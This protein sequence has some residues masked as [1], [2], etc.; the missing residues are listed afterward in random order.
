MRAPML[1]LWIIV[2]V[3]AFAIARRLYDVR[4]AIWSVLL[5]NVLPP[6]F[7]KS[8]EFRTDNLWNALWMLAV[9]ALMSKRFLAAGLLLGLATATSMKTPPSRKM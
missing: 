7:L 8:I 9:V 4:V 2:S 1:V 6:F 5:L 3:A